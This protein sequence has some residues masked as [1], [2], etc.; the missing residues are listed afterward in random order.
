MNPFIVDIVVGAV[1]QQSWYRKNANTIH[2]GVAL[3]GSVL[4]FVAT[5]AVAQDP[6]WAAGLA[7]AVQTIGVVGIKLTRN[8][9]QE[10]AAPMLAAAAPADP[11]PA[12]A[13]TVWSD[14]VEVVEGRIGKHRLE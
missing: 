5:L 11:R 10:S 13:D 2:A 1:R 7:F 3:L 4:T 9:L 14:L 8:G 12:L 6:R